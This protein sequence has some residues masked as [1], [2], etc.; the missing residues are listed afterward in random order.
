MFFA[1]KLDFEEDISKLIPQSEE[2]KTLNKVLNNTDFSDKI[3]VNIS[4]RKD[5][6]AENL[7]AYAEEIIDSLQLHCNDY[8]LNIQGEISNDDMVNTMD[9][10]YNNLP[11]FMEE[12]DYQYLKDRFSED[13]LTSVVTNNFKTLIS[14]SG[15][16][17]KNT[18][19]KDP[20]GLSF[21]ALKKLEDLKLTDNFEIYN[22][23]LIT[24]DKKNLLLFI[25]PKLS[26]NETDANT[27][28]VSKL[29]AISDSLNQ[30]YKD[31]VSSEYYGSTVIAVANAS[32]IKTDI[33]YTVT[34]ALLVLIFILI[35]FY[36][37]LFI[38]ILLF[39]PTIFGALTAMV[40]LSI[41]REN[42]SAISLGIGSVLLGITLDY[43]L[44]ILTHYR[45]NN[46]VKQLYKDVTKPILMSSI[47]TAVAFL[48]L[49]L[50]RSQALQDLGIF[51]AISVISTS[52]FALLIIP[53]FYKPKFQKGKLSK[54][55]IEVIANYSFDKNKFIYIGIFIVLI[56]SF[57]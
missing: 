8:I 12:K 41:I 29:Y 32:Q 38:P 24:K 10:V 34:L 47:T 45:N 15:L 9:F 33:K 14:P 17:A 44:H 52:I 51:A 31:V 25:K 20:F 55:F 4:T 23:F 36:R 30:K 1:T 5:G 56:L 22:G 53:L 2:T 54:N 13:S 7:I 37:K 3:I 48:C 42:I 6:T 18:I 26:T 49:L 40:I 28:F 21:R 57:F 50:L 39:I 19:R 46:D 11:L 16:I 43:S 27:D 35:F